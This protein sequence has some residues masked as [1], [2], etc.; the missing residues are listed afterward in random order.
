MYSKLK[1]KGSVHNSMALNY[2]I[3]CVTVKTGG[4]TILHD[5]FSSLSL[6][7]YTLQLISKLVIICQK[8]VVK[9]GYR[10]IRSPNF[11]Q[12]KKCFQIEMKFLLFSI[13]F[14]WIIITSNGRVYVKGDI[15][16][17]YVRIF[18]EPK[19]RSK[20]FSPKT[21]WLTHKNM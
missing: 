5:V 7:E 21:F 20:N 6:K 17:W 12:R 10:N 3:I 2:F 1:W 19:G 13:I 18:S 15:P 16:N 4:S 8:H 14:D 9:F 11:N